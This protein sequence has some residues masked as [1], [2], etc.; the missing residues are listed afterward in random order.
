MVVRLRLSRQGPKN[1]PFYHLVAI[2][3]A[4]RRD[5]RPIE[6]LGEY[7]PVPKVVANPATGSQS[8]F[9]ERPHGT[10]HPAQ[11]SRTGLFTSGIASARNA[12]LEKRMEWNRQ[13]IAYWLGVGAQPTETVARLLFRV[14]DCMYAAQV[15]V[16]AGVDSHG[17]PTIL[18]EHHRPGW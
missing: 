9:S 2:R 13:R 14:S 6:K 5:A 16:R 18:L 3:N 10:P 4:A 17:H 11:D 8:S 1:S 15:Q 7:D 12:K